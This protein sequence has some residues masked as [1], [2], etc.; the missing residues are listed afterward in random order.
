MGA[1]ATHDQPA[2]VRAFRS[3]Q[4]RAESLCVQRA[5]AGDDRGAK[6]SGY[7]Q[8]SMCDKFVRG[9][10]ATGNSGMNRS[11][12]ISECR[13]ARYWR[14][15]AECLNVGAQLGVDE[16]DEEPEGEAATPSAA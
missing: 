16:E 11:Q 10:C 14:T 6:I 3:F 12:Q 13:I 15:G 5:D 9:E 2:D 7:R 1:Q 4:F 8:H